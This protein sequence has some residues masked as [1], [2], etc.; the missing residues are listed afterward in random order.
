MAK[1]TGDRIFFHEKVLEILNETSPEK[2]MQKK[3]MLEILKQRYDITPT[4]TTLDR[5][6]ADLE[7]KGY[8]LVNAG[9]KGFYLERSDDSLSDGELRILIDSIM[10]SKVVT[11]DDSPAIIEKIAKLGSGDFQKEMKKRSHAATYIKKDVYWG[12]VDSVELVQ[13]AIFTGKQI[14]CNYIL[15]FD[16]YEFDYK[17]VENVVINPYE[18]AFSNGKYYLL[19]SYENDEGLSVLRV[20]RLDLI[21]VLSSNCVENDALKKVKDQN[22]Q[23]YI[24][25]QPELK[26]GQPE[27]FDLLCYPE[28]I[29]AVYDAFGSSNI[30]D[31]ISRPENYDDPDTKLVS[32]RTTREAVKS[33]AVFHADSVVVIKPQDLR[34]EI[35]EALKTAEHTYLKSGK[36]SRIRSWIARSLDEAIREVKNAGKKAVHY[37]GHGKKKQLEKIDLADYDITG[38]RDLS[39][40]CCDVK[41]SKSDSVYPDMKHLYFIRGCFAPDIY[42]HFP[43]LTHITVSGSDINN[44]DFIKQY[45]KL[46]VLR[47]VECGTVADFSPVFELNELKVFETDSEQFNEEMVEK[48][49]QKFP[50]C[51]IRIVEPR[52]KRG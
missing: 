7:T 13:K 50:D 21:E 10:Y 11:E 5:K 9:R 2:P 43:S 52:K 25:S 12:T 51:K 16:S 38:L 3:R 49:R 29:E 18:L 28:G 36:P 22:L 37:T 1:G 20:D 40:W 35:A 14:S 34:D 46:F 41:C 6:L 4:R 33:W 47:I 17:F 39:L 48:L 26:G 19:C 15:S 44:I 8:N 27:S 24:Y 45:K 31:M 32:V 42:Q 23:S 30:R